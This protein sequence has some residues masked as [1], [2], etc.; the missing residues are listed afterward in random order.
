MFRQELS[1][2]GW[3]EGKNII[4]EYRF[5]EQKTERLTELAEELVR[6]K[7]DLIVVNAGAVAALAAKKRHRYHSHR[8]DERCGP[9]GRRVGCKSSPAGWK[10]DGFSTAQS[11]EL[12]T[13][14]LEILEGRGPQAKPSLCLVGCRSSM[15]RLQASS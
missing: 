7:I 9:C 8:N 5:A 10:C 6:L 14:R 2:L 4:I 15:A 13:K 12:N 3:L 11:V 1:K